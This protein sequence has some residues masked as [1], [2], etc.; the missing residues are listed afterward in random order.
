M[1]SVWMAVN[2][3]SCVNPSGQ[4]SFIELLI[5]FW[6]LNLSLLTGSIKKSSFK[7]PFNYLTVPLL[8]AYSEKIIKQDLFSLTCVITAVS[9]NS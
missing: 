5:P 6:N 1:Y 3:Q 9:H 8:E 4:N 2:R 7:E